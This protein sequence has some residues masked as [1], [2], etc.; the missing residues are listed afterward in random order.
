MVKKTLGISSFLKKRKY[1]KNIVKLK[2]NDGTE[3]EDQ[4]AILREEEKCYTTLYEADSINTGSPESNQ[5]STLTC[6]FLLIFPLGNQFRFCWLPMV[7]LRLPTFKRPLA[8]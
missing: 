2:L 3:T 7:F 6:T 4:G 8:H 5:C 1:E